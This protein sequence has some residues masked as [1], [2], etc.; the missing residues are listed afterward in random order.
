MQLGYNFLKEYVADDDAFD[1]YYEESKC[2]ELSRFSLDKLCTLGFLIKIN[3]CGEL[4]LHVNSPSTQSKLT[5][6]I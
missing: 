5:Y 2:S 6:W 1:E 4:S 3:S